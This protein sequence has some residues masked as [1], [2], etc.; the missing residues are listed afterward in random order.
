MIRAT[1][2]KWVG[3]VYT[4]NVN[5][6]MCETYMAKINKIKE[7]GKGQEVLDL[8]KKGL[9]LHSIAKMVNTTLD[10]GRSISFMSVKRFL[11][12][13][14]VEEV[15]ADLQSGIDPSMKIYDT[16]KLEMD[17][18][19]HQITNRMEDIDELVVDAKEEKD[20][21]KLIKLISLQKDY[22]DQI[23]K[24]LVSLIQYSENRFRP[25]MNVS[26]HKDIKVKNLLIDFSKE[27]CPVCRSKVVAQLFGEE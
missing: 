18:L 15:N 2:G 23:R 19:K 5:K 1:I 16:F 7:Y 27:L 21:K 25:I 24:H 12:D 3:I 9:T 20:V 8:K 17:T 6:R 26:L 11:E 4:S 10:G 13:D 14:A 22:Y